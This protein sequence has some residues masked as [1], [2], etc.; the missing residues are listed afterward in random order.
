MFKFESITP[1][2]DP[3]AVEVFLRMS[4]P[5]SRYLDDNFTS[6]LDAA[7]G[8]PPTPELVKLFASAG[9]HI[10]ERVFSAQE[11]DG[12]LVSSICWD[13]IRTDAATPSLPSAAPLKS[14]FDGH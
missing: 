10:C 4:D 3:L 9:V 11:A 2:P 13:A 12:E 1:N 7:A 8:A 6:E 5:P 14:W